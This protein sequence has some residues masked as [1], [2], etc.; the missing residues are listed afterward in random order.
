MT[1]KRSIKRTFALLSIGVAVAGCASVM[2][3]TN[4]Q[5][6]SDKMEKAL[7]SQEHNGMSAAPKSNP[8]PQQHP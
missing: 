6:R 4:A 8:N 7:A 2:D 5:S 1:E 3:P